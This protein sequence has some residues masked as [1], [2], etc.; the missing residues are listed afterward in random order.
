MQFDSQGR[1]FGVYRTELELK[2]IQF[3]K[4]VIKEPLDEDSLKL[5]E[6]VLQPFYDGY[7]SGQY[8]LSG[9][10]ELQNRIDEFLSIVGKDID[11]GH[12]Y[13]SYDYEKVFGL[14]NELGL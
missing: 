1:L 7:K 6:H 9:D 3:F 8:N 2:A 13:S 12:L 11:G 5:K 4:D 14:I 10:L